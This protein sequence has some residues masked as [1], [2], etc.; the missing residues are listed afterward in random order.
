MVEII[1][2]EL[3]DIIE[4]E[5]IRDVYRKDIITYKKNRRISLGPNVT[6]VFE[7]KKTLIFQIQEIMRAE[8]LVHD[9]Q[10][11]NEIDVY[12]SIL[13]PKDGLSA[14]LFLEITEEKKI[15]TVLDSFIGLSLGNSIY[16]QIGNIKKNAIFEAGRE[17][18]DNI[19]SVHYIKFKFDQNFLFDFKDKNKKVSLVIEHNKYNYSIELLNGIR[20]SLINDLEEIFE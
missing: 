11:Q 15:R 13:P 5:K 4:Y 6:L 14:T 2:Q 19:S 16:F 18:D 7:N 8:R 20:D 1:K 12:T 10:I 3:L 9:N 17:K